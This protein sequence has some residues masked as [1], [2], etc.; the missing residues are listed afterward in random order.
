MQSFMPIAAIAVV[1]FYLGWVYRNRRRGRAPVKAAPGIDRLWE[2]LF[3]DQSLSDFLS[4]Q[5]GVTW[6]EFRKALEAG[7][8]GKND[9]AVAALKKALAAPGLETRVALL[10]WNSLREFGVLPSAAEAEVVRGVVVEIPIQG[11]AVV[12]AVYRD[13]RARLFSWRGKAILWEPTP[14]KEVS[15][16][17]ER[18]LADS[19]ALFSTAQ[20]GRKCTAIPEGINRVSLLTFGGIRTFDARKSEPVAID[21]SVGALIRA[22]TAIET[23]SVQG[24]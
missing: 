5:P 4:E 2:L 8:Q 15:T 19:Q 6:P 11:D 22:L 10:I 3:A 18:V 9:D 16:L 17:L 13:G 20:P 23:K 7:R 24:G 14:D 21:S 1:I 12:L